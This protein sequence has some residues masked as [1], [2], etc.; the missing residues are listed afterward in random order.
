LTGAEVL[1]LVASQAGHVY[2]F[3]TPRLQPII[4]EPRGRDL[5]QHLLEQ[6][7]DVSQAAAIANS[8]T[9][10]AAA[11]DDDGEH[12]GDQSSDDGGE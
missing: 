8:N 1:L 5:I 7:I 3:A 9:A 10:A 11:A 6:D 2:T 12:T 4:S